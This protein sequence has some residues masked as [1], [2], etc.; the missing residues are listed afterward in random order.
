MNKIL[1]TILLFIFLPTL[2][3]ADTTFSAPNG[4]SHLIKSESPYILNSNITIATGTTLTIEP[5]VCVK[6]NAN[7]GFSIQGNLVARGTLDEPIV[8]TSIKNDSLCGDSNNDAT[9]TAA[10][11]GDWTGLSIYNSATLDHVEIS[12]ANSGVSVNSGDLQ[13]LSSNIHDNADRGISIFD[14]NSVEVSNTSFSNNRYPIDISTDIPFVHSGNSASGNQVN[15][16]AIGG[17]SRGGVHLSKDNIPYYTNN[18]YI[19]T[20]TSVTIDPGVCVKMGTVGS[21]YT[22]GSLILNGTKEV[23]IYITSVKD[24]SVCGDTNGDGTATS[25]NFGD[26][27]RMQVVSGGSL[28]ASYT[29]VRYAGVQSNDGYH[30]NIVNNGGDVILNNSTSTNALSAGFHQILGTSTIINSSFANQTVGVQI[31]GGDMTIHRSSFENNFGSAIDTSNITNSSTTINATG[32]WWG[33]EDGPRHFS[34]K[35]SG[36]GQWI[37]GNNIDF[38]DWLQG[39]PKTWVIDPVIII[40]GI[41]GSWKDWH[42]VWRLDPITHTYDNLV[43]TFIANGYLRGSTLYEFPYDWEK[44]NVDTAILLKQ[45]IADVKATCGCSKVDIVAHSMGGLVARQYIQSADYQNDV[46]QIIFMGTPHLGSVFAYLAY[47]GGDLGQGIQ[48]FIK[49]KLLGYIGNKRGFG[50]L[51]HYARNGVLSL[52]EI[53]PIT[54][55]INNNSGIVL[56]Y[57]NGYPRNGFLE[58]LDNNLPLLSQRV[59]SIKNFVG[60]IGT[61]STKILLTVASSTSD[62][63]FDGEPVSIEF[64]NGDGTVSTTSAARVIQKIS[65][66]DFEHSSLVTGVE[67]QVLNELTLNSDLNLIDKHQTTNVLIFFVNSPIDITVTSPGG[68]TFGIN[69]TSNDSDN[70]FYTNNGDEEF[71]VID[72]PEQGQY[73]ISSVGTGQGEYSVGVHLISDNSDVEASTSGTTDIGQVDATNFLISNNAIQIVNPNIPVTTNSS[74]AVITISNIQSSV[75]IPENATTTQIAPASHNLN[76]RVVPMSN[77]LLSKVDVL[78]YPI[79]NQVASA[80]SSSWGSRFGDFVAR[81]FKSLIELLVGK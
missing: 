80:Q 73:Q 56:Q 51:F 11:A 34:E 6:V 1:L 52:K 33:T 28:T 70:A 75:K 74:N 24:D 67:S 22:Q 39:N 4:D 62:K 72:N 71:L 35:V 20:G 44:S 81:K 45:K 5:G 36:T 23:P 42:G 40:P 15:A 19:A 60:D 10:M 41:L 46:D 69:G 48:N 76:E 14:A 57:P 49:E 21:M 32:N 29:V 25:P 47:E 61:T 53:L 12:F 31:D 50:D 78:K 3:H 18:F 37:N 17:H 68:Q 7:F 8:F 38:S 54:N 79:N 9:T 26:W 2:S 65:I 77:W 43:D 27:V 55:Y 59:R 58:N 64:G 13:V 63:W 16:L 66:H 30:A